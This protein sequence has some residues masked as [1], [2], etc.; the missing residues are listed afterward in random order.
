[1]IEV[2]HRIRKS[3][4][5]YS[6][7]FSNAMHNCGP[8]SSG[9]PKCMMMCWELFQLYIRGILPFLYIIFVFPPPELNIYNTFTDGIG[10]P[11]LATSII[12]TSEPLISI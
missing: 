11:Q 6:A 1:M 2:M 10:F 8:P 9:C 4:G 12:T 3:H 7:L 5:S